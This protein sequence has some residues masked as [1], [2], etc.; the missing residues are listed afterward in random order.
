VGCESYSEE[1][2]RRVSVNKAD[3]MMNTVDCL[4]LSDKKINEPPKLAD[5]SQ[6]C[7]DYSFEVKRLPK[8]AFELN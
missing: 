3:A 4:E 7:Q 8:S 5:I 2:P 1:P 6:Y